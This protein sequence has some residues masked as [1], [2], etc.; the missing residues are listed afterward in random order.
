MSES[1]H[2]VVITGAGVVSPFGRG[3]DALWQALLEGRRSSGR[4]DRYKPPANLDPEAVALL[5]RRSLYA[6]D[7]AIQ[8]IEDAHLPVTAQS[9]PLIG[10]VWGSS[11][12]RGNEPPA[13]QVARV[14]G[15]A[16]PALTLEGASSGSQAVGES[17]EMIAR[18]QAPVVVAGGTSALDAS[19]PAGSGRPFDAGRD[20]RMPAEGAAAFVLESEAI[21]RDRGAHVYAE[22]VGY[23]A[24]FSRSTVMTPGANHVDAA[25]AVQQALVRAQVLQGE[26]E[27]VFAAAAGDETDQI[28]VRGLGELW[29]P[30]VDRLTVTS[31]HGAT[32]YAFAAAGP[33]SLAVALKSLEEGTLPP[34][35]GCDKPDESFRDLDIVL[36]QRTYRFSTALVDDLGAGTNVALLVRRD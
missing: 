8:A 15:V 4:V 25:R 23:G 2:R 7:A 18:R 6:V 12:A 24:A 17:L 28:E 21:A 13:S 33:L 5:D 1:P 29:G 22:L 16:G 9:A 20:G 36:R 3:L 34:T 14:L 30:N 26:V 27:V 11:G 35:A 31:V 32:G 19:T 10:V